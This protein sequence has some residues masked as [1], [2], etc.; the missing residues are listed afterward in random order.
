MNK[1]FLSILIVAVIILMASVT[2]S[3]DNSGTVYISA[4][5]GI[6]I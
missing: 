6:G 5:E 1:R 4:S 2:V 3:A